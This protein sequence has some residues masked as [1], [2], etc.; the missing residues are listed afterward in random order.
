MKG[1]AC[2][3]ETEDQAT[4]TVFVGRIV[5]DNLAPLND[6]FHLQSGDLAL[7]GGSTRTPS[8]GSVLESRRSSAQYTAADRFRGCD[9]QSKLVRGDIQDLST[10]QDFAGCRAVVQKV[11]DIRTLCKKFEERGCR[12]RHTDYVSNPRETGYRGVHIIAEYAGRNRHDH[13]GLKVEVQLRTRLQHRWATA[14][15]A[16]SFVGF[17]GSLKNGK[18]DQRWLE[19]F[20]VMSDV[21]AVA[22]NAGVTHGM[23][24][25]PAELAKSVK[26]YQL[27]LNVQNALGGIRLAGQILRDPPSLRLKEF[28]CFVITMDADRLGSGVGAFDPDHLE[29]ANAMAR[30]AE[31]AGHNAV[32]VLA[33]DL[34]ALMAGYPSYFRDVTIFSRNVLSA[35]YGG[36]F[37]VEV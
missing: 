35:A 7:D 2:C 19:F 18:G 10:M 30:E 5:F 34:K 31:L 36:D 11:A 6:L 4:R 32:L 24:K 26:S 12:F 37:E 33:D 29:D 25:I 22:D 1:T 3:R 20:K 9:I 14:V 27:E 8:A 15:E 13:D 16:L 17:F 28:N 23:M 21:Y